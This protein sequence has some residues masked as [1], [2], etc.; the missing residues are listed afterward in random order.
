MAAVDSPRTDATLSDYT[1]VGQ[2]CASST[3]PWYAP[4]GELSWSSDPTAPVLSCD[5]LSTPTANASGLRGVTA[6][7]V[8]DADLWAS[9]S[10]G[11]DRYQ[12]VRGLFSRVEHLTFGGGATALAVTPHE[13]AVA[14]GTTVTLY[15]YDA[16]AWST[17]G[18]T[19]VCDSVVTL[20]FDGDT[21]WAVG[22]A[23]VTPIATTLTSISA[24][25]AYVLGIDSDGLE[26]LVP[27][28]SGCPA[29][30]MEA[31]RFASL[32]GR[33][34]VIGT[35]QRIQTYDLR[36]AP[37]LLFVGTYAVGSTETLGAARADGQFVYGRIDTAAG[38]AYSAF[39]I[40]PTEAFLAAGTAAASAWVDGA[41]VG[42][43]IATRYNGASW[44]VETW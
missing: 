43:G 28:S 40:G 20:S 42:S 10:T 14:A 11:L 24:L 15:R 3:A 41:Q 38:P 33:H 32:A 30:T 39:R 5:A 16:G 21:I 27:A 36:S 18:T 7:M 1:G 9:S 19:T 8:H 26:R 25:P 35:S 29:G 34:L 17:V 6:V 37:S 44:D 23:Y 4:P 12:S 2:L 22:A 13:V 31:I